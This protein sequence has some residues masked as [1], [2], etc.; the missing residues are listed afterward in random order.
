MRPRRALRRRP[1]PAAPRGLVERATVDRRGGMRDARARIL[2]TPLPRAERL[3]HLIR[4]ESL[5]DEIAIDPLKL[6]IVLDRV[7]AAQALHQRGLKQRA[8]VDRTEH[9][10]DR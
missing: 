9:V 4:L 7:A 5:R 10:V 1:S 8:V 3:N 6:P 2:S